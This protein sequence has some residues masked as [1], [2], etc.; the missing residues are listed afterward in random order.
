MMFVGGFKMIAPQ[1]IHGIR[2]EGFVEVDAAQTSP[3]SLTDSRTPHPE[4]TFPNACVPSEAFVAHFASEYCLQKLDFL[5]RYPSYFIHELTVLSAIR[6]ILI[7]PRR[8]A[9]RRCREFS[10]R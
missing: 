1:F 9:V 10:A 6:C 7:P 2:P 8:E 4:K 5:L 3:D